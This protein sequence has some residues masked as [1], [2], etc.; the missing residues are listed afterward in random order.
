MYK[1]NH[2]W[3]STLRHTSISFTTIRHINKI[4]YGIT[5]RTRFWL[6]INLFRELLHER[7]N[8]NRLK[9]DLQKRYSKAILIKT[10]VQDVKKHTPY[11]SYVLQFVARMDYSILRVLKRCWRSTWNPERRSAPWRACWVRRGVYSRR[12]MF[13]WTRPT[14]RRWRPPRETGRVWGGRP[15]GRRPDRPGRGCSSDPRGNPVRPAAQASANAAAPTTR[16]ACTPDRLAPA[17]RTATRRRPVASSG[18]P[19]SWHY[20]QRSAPPAAP[21][22]ARRRRRRRARNL[23]AVTQRA[24]APPATA[25][26]RRRSGTARSARPPPRCATTG[27][28]IDGNAS[29]LV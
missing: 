10:H 12:G 19:A 28:L 24:A 13:C 22:P 4:T 7:H 29:L 8:A 6:E 15:R 21:G 2:S 27:S 20:A 9:K 26:T 18:A 11:P 5:R 16:A 25:P 3:R 1:S 23:A 17:A 14:C